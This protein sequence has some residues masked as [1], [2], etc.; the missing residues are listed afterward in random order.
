MYLKFEVFAGLLFTKHCKIIPGILVTI[1]LHFRV[2]DYDLLVFNITCSSSYFVYLLKT[3]L[4][5]F[6]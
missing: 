3:C 2:G 6:V 4:A 1:I 5:L